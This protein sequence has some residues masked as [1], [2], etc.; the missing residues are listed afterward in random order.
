MLNEQVKNKKSLPSDSEEFDEVLIK[1]GENINERSIIPRRPLS[2]HYCVLCNRNTNDKTYWGEAWQNYFFSCKNCK[3]VWCADCMG[4]VSGFG[5]RK[6]F[7]QGK[8]GKINC[9]QCGQFVPVIKL[10]FKLPFVQEKVE[11]E[12]NHVEPI[13]TKFCGLCGYK[14]NATAKFCENC[15]G[16]QHHYI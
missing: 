9:P 8:K 6:T 10:P 1:K 16:E 12:K 4:Q 14:I 3:S 5:P 7:K 2:D 13:K 15:G 11:K